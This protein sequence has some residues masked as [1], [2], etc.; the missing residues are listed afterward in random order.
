MLADW[1][2]DRPADWA[3]F[4]NEPQSAE[5]LESLRRSVNRGCPFG[6]D[7]WRD[8]MVDELGLESTVRDRGRPSRR[9][10]VEEARSAIQ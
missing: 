8:K 2:I 3:Q 10:M 7:Q 6:E 9:R 1:P 4:V 5:E